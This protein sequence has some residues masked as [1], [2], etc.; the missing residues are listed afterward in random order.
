M[1]SPN[2][3]AHGNGNRDGNGAPPLRIVFW[4]TTGPHRST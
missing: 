1:S 3:H 4:E 2:P